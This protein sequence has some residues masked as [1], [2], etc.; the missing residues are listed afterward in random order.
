MK[1]IQNQYIA[2][3]IGQLSK[4]NNPISGNKNYVKYK[5]TIVFT[6]KLVQHHPLSIVSIAKKNRNGHNLLGFVT[7]SNYFYPL[8]H[9]G[10]QAERK[11]CYLFTIPKLSS[12]C[13]CRYFMLEQENITEY[14]VAIPYILNDIIT[15]ERKLFFLLQSL[16]RN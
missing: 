5:N 3:D 16:V 8:Q 15:H 9:I 12:V 4:H 7:S 13:D 1:N 14:I 6:S 2:H 10:F 11:Y